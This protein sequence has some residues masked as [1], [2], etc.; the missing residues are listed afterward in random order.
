MSM[1]TASSLLLEELL[2]DFNNV[3]DEPHDLPPSRSRDHSIT[4]MPGAPPVAI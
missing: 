4:L 1:T 2:A 3:F